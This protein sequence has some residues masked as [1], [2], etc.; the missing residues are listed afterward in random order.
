GYDPKPLLH[1]NA[2]TKAA[3]V[4]LTKSLAKELIERGIRA[5]SVAPGPIWSPL[6]IS[7]GQPQDKL[8]EFG[9]HYMMGRSGQPGELAS[10]YVLLASDE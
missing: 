6:H 1:A 10:T 2:A 4:S 9:Q 8:P 7:G 3:L 5:N